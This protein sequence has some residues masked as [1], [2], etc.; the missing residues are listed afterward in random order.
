MTKPPEWAAAHTPRK[1]D[2]AQRWQ[3]LRDH[4][5]AVAEDAQRFAQHFAVPHASEFAYWSGILHDLGKY[6]Q[7][8]QTYLRVAYRADQTKTRGP[9]KKVDHSSAG[10]VLGRDLLITGYEE[11]VPTDGTGAELAWVVAYHHGRLKDRVALM[12]RLSRQKQ[13]SGVAQA[14]IRAF[15]ELE[16]VF[17]K[18]PPE[19]AELE[20]FA[21]EFFIRMLLS[22]VV[23]ADRLDTEKFWSPK[24]SAQRQHTKAPLATLLGKV[25]EDQ[26]KLKSLDTLVNRA[27]WDI[28]QAALSAARREPG[29]FR[30]TVP[31]GGG[32]T[33]SSLAFALEHAVA[34]GLRRVIYA[35]PFT[36]II[37]QTADVFTGLL[38]AENVLEHHSAYEPDDTEDENRTKLAAENWDVPVVVTTNVQ[39][40]ESLFA[41]K[42]S[43]LRKLHNLAGSVLI[44]DEV[45]TLPA[46]LLQPTLSALAELVRSYRVSI[47]FCTATQ[48]AL[49]AALGFTTLQNVREIVP[50]P[51][52]YFQQ[53]KRVEYRTEL[54]PKPWE[55]VA[56]ELHRHKQ[57]LCIVNTK[58]QAQD[59][60]TALADPEAVHLSTNLYPAHRREV[61]ADIRGRLS[62]GKACR[63]ISTQLVEAGVD[64]DFPA[65]FRALGPLDSLVQAAGRCN[66]EGKLERDGQL[67][68]GEV[69]VFRPEQEGLPK[70]AYASATKLSRNKLEQGED[71]DHPELFR[72]Y[73]TELYRDLIETDAKQI[74]SLRGRFDYTE[75]AKRYRLID[76]N[77]FPVLVRKREKDKAIIEKI[78]ERHMGFMA[79][80][81]LQP[82]IVNVYSSR[83]EDLELYMQPL[84][85]DRLDAELWEWTGQYDEKL[86][87]VELFD[88]NVW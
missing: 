26:E 25:K 20:P 32:K 78:L 44:L 33:R 17:T 4:L 27:R 5:E 10:A 43:K 8:F 63:V 2:P 36:S 13:D 14:Q 3:P 30:L 19:V 38:G 74:Q 75:V 46:D 85:I 55:Q 60:F 66:R 59:L 77:T 1:D 61:L 6:S 84:V 71:L 56:G 81:K 51:E 76:D 45:Q 67:V 21:R 53:L 37:D 29:F 52:R 54:E 65:V 41:D 88:A 73:F 11:L 82:Y 24:T 64:L 72:T 22:T 18:S 40:F 34:F 69:T 42:T 28:Y 70:G 58:K 39:L 9:S 23:D 79:L 83:K 47:V 50:Q 68:L 87:I 7:E 31:T 15:E 49:D 86:G 62:E 48:P 16:D 35:V 12:E 57:V 80:R